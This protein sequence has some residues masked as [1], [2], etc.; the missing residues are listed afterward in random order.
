VPKQ[1]PFWIVTLDIAK[2]WFMSPVKLAGGTKVLWYARE[3]YVRDCE[4]K[5]QIKDRQ[6]NG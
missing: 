3:A 2:R 1:A 5:R 6:K 4:V